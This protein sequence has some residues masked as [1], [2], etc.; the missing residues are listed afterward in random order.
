MPVPEQRKPLESGVHE[1]KPKEAEEDLEVDV[2]VSELDEPG[3]PDEVDVNLAGLEEDIP[4]PSAKVIEKAREGEMTTIESVQQLVPNAAALWEVLNQQFEKAPAVSQQ[5]EQAA[6]KHI[7]Q[8]ADPAAEIVLMIGAYRNFRDNIGNQEKAEEVRKDI[9]DLAT[10][11]NAAD[12]PEL[13][14]AME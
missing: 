9:V 7:I 5:I 12:N 13:Q 1:T 10:M 14:K 3:N 2:D 6:K 11:L 4:A 8:V